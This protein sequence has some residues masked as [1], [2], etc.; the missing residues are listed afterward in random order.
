MQKTRKVP[1]KQSINKKFTPTS[2]T[3]T[4][5]KHDNVRKYKIENL[6][7]DLNYSSN[8]KELRIICNLRKETTSIKIQFCTTSLNLKTKIKAKR[9]N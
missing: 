1:L 8:L 4:N 9:V 3:N 7:K 2:N 6:D 5:I